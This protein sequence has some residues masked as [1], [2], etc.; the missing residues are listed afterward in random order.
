[1]RLD[2]FLKVSRIIKR[3]T[4]AAQACDGDRVLLNGREAKPAAKVKVGDII[5]VTFGSRTTRYEVLELRES[6]TIE[7]ASG[8]VRPLG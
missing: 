5:E 1:M 7:Q 4:V 2:K 3:R 8:M 6:A